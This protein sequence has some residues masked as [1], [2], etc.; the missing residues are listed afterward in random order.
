MTYVCNICKSD[1]IYFDAWVDQ[2]GEVV[3]TFDN[4]YCPQCEGE[5][6]PLEVNDDN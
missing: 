4:C 5:C 6:F 2:N 1:N 3:S